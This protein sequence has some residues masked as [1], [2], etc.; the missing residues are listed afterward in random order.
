MLHSEWKSEF[1]T[2]L[3]VIDSDDSQRCENLVFSHGFLRFEKSCPCHIFLPN[4]E[5]AGRARAA[6]CV[7]CALAVCAA[8]LADRKREKKHGIFG[9][10][11]CGRAWPR[12][13][14]VAAT[15]ARG[16][17]YS[18]SMHARTRPARVGCVFRAA[19]RS[20]GRCENPHAFGCY[21]TTEEGVKKRR[22]EGM[23]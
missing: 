7:L 16:T 8:S 3:T 9:F 20:R 23:V 2:F 17:F 21:L 18:C 11:P 12:G 15:P 13:R 10:S 4:T 14:Q 5:R 6:C 1:S 22:M 19:G